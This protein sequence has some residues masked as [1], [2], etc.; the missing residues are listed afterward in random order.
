M[1]LLTMFLAPIVAMDMAPSVS[2]RDYHDLVAEGYR[3][4]EIDGPYACP[5]KEDLREVTRDHSDRNEL[6]MIE[7]VR[8]Y[9]LIQGALVKIIQQEASTGMA[10]IRVAGINV[11][12]WTFSKFLSELPIKNAYAAIETPETSGL[13]PADISDES[14]VLEGA[15]GT[16]W[17][18]PPVAGKGFEDPEHLW[19]QPAPGGSNSGK[20]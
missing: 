9:F 13:I 7:G 16:A 10:Q 15:T 11:D 3:W 1:K 14:G 8:A 2:A 20:R 19:E 18:S 4:V 12:L 6:H 17:S 5:T